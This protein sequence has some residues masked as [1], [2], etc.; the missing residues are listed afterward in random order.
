VLDDGTPLSE[1]TT[2]V[3]YLDELHGATSIVGQTPSSRA[4]TDQ[5]LNRVDAKIEIPMGEAFRA[6][7]MLKFFESRRPGC[8]HPAHVPGARTTAQA[9]L[10]WLDSV[11]ADGRAYLCGE[12]F[13]LADIRFFC[14]IGFYSRSDPSQKLPAGLTHLNAYMGRLA[15]RPSAQ[16]IAPPKRSKM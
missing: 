5:W 13:T 9:G 4:L 14:N 1:S 16:A 15:A 12:R 11:L 6:G 7:P 10:K 8:I 3:K 2:I